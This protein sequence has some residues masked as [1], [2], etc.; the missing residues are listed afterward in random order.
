[1]QHL[2]A[3]KI[4]IQNKVS[5]SDI[6][7]KVYVAYPSFVFAENSNLKF[8]IFNEIANRWD[9]PI[10]QIL[11]TGSAHTGESFHKEAKFQPGIS[12]LDVAI[13]SE[14]LFLKF[15]EESNIAT[16]GYFDL[17][18]FER[19]DGHDTSTAFMTNLARGF[20]RPDLMP[21]CLLKKTW[22]DFFQKI[23]Q[24]H[25]KLFKSINAGIYTSLN[26]FEAKQLENIKFA[27]ELKTERN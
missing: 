2:N 14:K 27:G 1:M 3:I 4:D 12:D 23:S 13:V 10:N 26:C 7:R 25:L 18:R 20:F 16:R 17:S 5:P 24:K 21:Q 9:I 22:F 11:L 15:L 8:E 6:A 19:L